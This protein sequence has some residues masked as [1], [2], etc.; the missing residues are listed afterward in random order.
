MWQNPHFNDILRCLRQRK[1]AQAYEQTQNYLLTH[2]RQGDYEELSRIGEDYELLSGYWQRGYDD[3][4]RD[5]LYEQLLRRLYVFVANIAIH[6]RI[7]KS[8]M[9]SQA[10]HTAATKLKDGSVAFLRHQLEEYV[11]SVAMLGLEPE[12]Q[13][14]QKG[15]QLHAEHQQFMSAVFAAFLTSRQ[16][17]DT[18]VEPLRE[19]LL[20]PTVDP[21]DQ[22]HIISALSLSAMNMFCMNKFRLLIDLSQQATIDSVRQRALVGWVLSA[23]ESLTTV[24]PEV[25]TA[26]KELC[27]S[28]QCRRELTELQLQMIYCMLADDDSQTIKNEI[29]PDLMKGNNLTITRRGIV[30]VDESSLEDILHPDAS[31]ADMERMEASMKKMAEMQRQ[32]SDIYFAGFSQMKRFPFFSDIANWFVPFYPQHP[33]IANIWNNTK[34]SKFLQIITRMGAF[35]DSDKYSFVLAFEQVLSHLPQSMLQMIERGEASPMAVG[36]EVPLEEQRQPAF[37]RRSYLQNLYRFFRLFNQRSEF[38]NP[39]DPDRVAFFASRLYQNT[40]LEENMVQV[41][42]FLMK[43]NMGKQALSVLDNLTPQHH[44][45]SY[46]LLMGQMLT[47]QPSI[48]SDRRQTASAH[49]REAMRIMPQHQRALM[50]F[51]RASFAEGNYEEALDTF[52]QLHELTPDNMGIELNITVCLIQQGRVEEALK[53]LHRLHYMDADNDSVTRVLAWA[54]TLT[55]SYEQANKL[56]ERLTGTGHPHNDDLLNYGYCLWL[57]KKLGEAITNFKRYVGQS[58]ADNA[59]EQ[60]FLTAEHDV[61]KAHGISDIEIQLMLDAVRG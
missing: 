50:G 52:N 2:A 43:H 20:S 18:D 49:Y 26:I 36:G 10:Q 14:R 4:Q 34:G 35:C 7:E 3:P 55:G 54:L 6:D 42:S 61:L 56:Y 27:A 17:R 59:L 40:Q 1:F 24:Y 45:L 15:E 12:H 23:E 39:F 46:H 53:P 47:A 19:L 33:L 51:A 30:E 28:E 8:S 22:Q 57:Q 11:S 5:R 29:M 9:L 16:L 38:S 48:A 31:E 37:I 58:E 25:K 13:R 60:E 44:G 41:A 21:I 32:G